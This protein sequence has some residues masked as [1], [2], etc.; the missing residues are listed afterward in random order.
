ML[1]P[2]APHLSEEL[3]EIRGNN[4]SVFSNTWPIFNKKHFSRKECL[5]L[6]F[7]TLAKALKS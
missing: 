5:I 1:A 2:F 6:P 3:W 4:D 7:K